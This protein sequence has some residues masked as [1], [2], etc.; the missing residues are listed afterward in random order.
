MT[1][2]RQLL[3]ASLAL[4]LGVGSLGGADAR[5][6]DSA[7]EVL[8]RVQ[9]TRIDEAELALKAMP[10]DTPGRAWAEASVLFHR[11]RYPAALAALPE[12]SPDEPNGLRHL[13][14]RIEQ[15]D[16]ATVGML[17]RTVG[18][19]TY[20]FEGGPDAILVDYAVDALE[21][22]R[23]YMEGLLGVAPS[24]PVLVEFFPTVDRFV[25]ATGLPREWVETTNTVAVCKWDRLMVLSPLN[26]PRGYPWKDTLAHEYVHLVLSQ[27]SRNRAPIWFHEGSAKVL[28][29][30]WR[31]PEGSNFLDPWGE[32][33]LARA[34]DEGA[35]V[36]FEAMHPSMAAL[37]S[38]EIASLAFAQVA[39]AVDFIIDN[40]GA[41]GYRRIVNDT[42]LHGDVLRAVDLALGRSLG[43][44]EDRYQAHMRSQGLRIRTQV[45]GFDLKLEEGAAGVADSEGVGLDPV[46]LE[47]RKMQDHARIGDL[48]RLRGHREAALIEYVRAEQV[49]AYHSPALANKKARTLRALGRTVAAQRVLEDSVALYPEF[50]PSVALLCE[51]SAATDQHQRT[52]SL[53]HR[54]L[55]MNPFDPQVHLHLIAA[56][57]GLGDSDGIKHEQRVMQIL[58]DHLGR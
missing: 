34:L 16:K 44:F 51:L 17:E 38:S 9:E 5:D 40:V 28:E 27:A 6:L 12:A 21:G 32:S 10:L 26:M 41:R 24:K 30:R 20:R 4:L 14:T 33:L 43:S 56:L 23:S 52:V 54:A 13:R 8:E 49:G 45:A 37:P 39:Y 15:A 11:G 25:R 19:F 58:A 48:L 3:V 55:A 29:S 50:T 7:K 53:A 46:L 2:R 22:Q 36:D 35:L 42:A 18:H 47:D 57:T 1:A 31:D